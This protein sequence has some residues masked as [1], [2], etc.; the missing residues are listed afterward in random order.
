MVNQPLTSHHGS[1]S[2]VPSHATEAQVHPQGPPGVLWNH[3]AGSP[4]A[5][6]RSSVRDL[7]AEP[8]A[9]VTWGFTSCGG[10]PRSCWSFFL[11]LLF[12]IVG[13]LVCWIVCCKTSLLFALIDLTK[14]QRNNKPTEQWTWLILKY[15]MVL[16]IKKNINEEQQRQPW[17]RPWG[18]VAPGVT[19]TVSPRHAEA[20]AWQ[21]AAQSC[22]R[23]EDRSART[24]GSG[25]NGP[26]GLFQQ[27]CMAFPP[28]FWSFCCLVF[29]S[30]CKL[31][32]FVFMWILR[33]K[34]L[35]AICALGFQVPSWWCLQIAHECSVWFSTPKPTKEPNGCHDTEGCELGH[36]WHSFYESA[37]FLYSLLDFGCHLRNSG[38]ILN[39]NYGLSCK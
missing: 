28:V 13:W 18:H 16:L 39:R 33:K 6:W 38:L 10:S 7:P 27:F 20:W 19:V 25:R 31:V 14:F 9:P 26:G 24:G 37:I 11:L 4:I 36:Q 8:K 29:C 22:A 32:F 35:A 3:G 34:A 23:A 12:V 1:F 30:F 2:L 21:V 15:L 5:T 17:H